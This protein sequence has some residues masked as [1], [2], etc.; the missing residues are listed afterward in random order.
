VTD[1]A[2]APAPS[3][4]PR[5]RLLGILTALLLA[6]LAQDAAAQKPRA[7][8]K[9]RAKKVQPTPKPQVA[10]PEEVARSVIQADSTGDWATLIRLAHPDALLRFRE[11]QSFQLRMLGRTDWPG[12]EFPAVPLDSTKQARWQ[13]A[14]ARQERL[15]LDSVF[16][17]PNV[18]SLAHTSPDTV[19]ARWVRWS[20]APM[21]RDSVGP[22][23]DSTARDSAPPMPR[24]R[25]PTVRVVGSVKASDTLA[26]VVVERALDQPLGPIPE[27]FRDYPRETH[28][29]E[30][31][32]M[33]KHGK[34]WRTMLDVASASLGLAADLE[35]EE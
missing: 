2:T 29:A 22:A 24:T 17:V 18:D 11:L 9:P 5:V 32:V 7:A 13:R 35:H 4:R 31:M 34:D 15:L 26:Y 33:R 8:T 19:F 28:H 21:P 3:A 1:S 25:E 27:M 20:R 6:C 23:S 14:R 10:P 12:T 30:V 16:Q